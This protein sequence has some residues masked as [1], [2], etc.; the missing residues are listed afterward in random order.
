MKNDAYLHIHNARTLLGVLLAYVE[1]DDYD[2]LRFA[3][4]TAFNEVAEAE[5]SIK[6]MR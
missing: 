6:N 2:D 4:E 1:D 5:E 3:I